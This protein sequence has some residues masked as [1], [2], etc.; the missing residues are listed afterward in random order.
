MAEEWYPLY[1]VLWSEHYKGLVRRRIDEYLIPRLGKRSL[2]EI[3]PIE[4]MGILTSLEKRVSLRRQIGFWGF[5]RRFS[6]GQ[7]PREK[8]RAIPAGICAGRWLRHRRSTMPP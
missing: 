2:S 3:T 4:I 1:S 8:P 5:A 7:W 6:E